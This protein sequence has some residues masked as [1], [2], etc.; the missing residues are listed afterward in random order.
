MNTIEFAVQEGVP[1]AIDF[2]NPAPDFERDRITP[3]YFEMCV[4]KM[5]DLVIDRARHGKPQQT[6]PRWA[7][8]TGLSD[9]SAV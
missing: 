2:L 5:A 4:Q 8:M 1:Y 9:S 3:F 7:Q 6:W